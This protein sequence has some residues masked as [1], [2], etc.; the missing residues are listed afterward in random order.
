MDDAQINDLCIIHPKLSSFFT[1]YHV[2]YFNWSHEKC[3]FFIFFAEKEMKYI[4]FLIP[5]LHFHLLVN[6]FCHI[7]SLTIY[8]SNYFFSV[9]CFNNLPH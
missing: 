6:Y 4:S 9:F 2:F 5:F 8:R 3:N 7:S 1:L